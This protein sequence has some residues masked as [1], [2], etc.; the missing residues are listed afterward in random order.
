MVGMMLG[1]R[2]G[3]KE[4]PSEVLDLAVCVQQEA[5]DE[6]EHNVTSKGDNGS[7]LPDNGSGRTPPGWHV[8]VAHLFC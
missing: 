2:E 5:F 3:N 7:G 1:L 4:R 8:T 6:I